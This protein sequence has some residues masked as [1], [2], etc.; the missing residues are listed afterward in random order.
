MIERLQHALTHLDDLPIDAQEDLAEQI[1]LLAGV[2][3]DLPKTPQTPESSTGNG[4]QMTDSLRAAL[5][6]IGSWAD[7]QDD[8]FEALDRIRH[9]STPTPPIELDV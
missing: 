8:E 9:A 5:A 6:A 2:T 4:F 1:E 7:K 3:A